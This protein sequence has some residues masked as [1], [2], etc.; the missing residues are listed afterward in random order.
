MFQ[1]EWR[2]TKLEVSVLAWLT[3]FLTVF[4]GFSRFSR[5]L[6]IFSKKHVLQLWLYHLL[7]VL[8]F[9]P[10]LRIICVATCKLSIENIVFN[11]SSRLNVLLLSYS[12]LTRATVYRCKLFSGRLLQLHTTTRVSTKCPWPR[13]VTGPRLQAQNKMINFV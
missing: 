2:S 1:S 11:R 10:F 9:G 8:Y 3:T 4:N 12:S 13:I 7:H 6:L 5:F